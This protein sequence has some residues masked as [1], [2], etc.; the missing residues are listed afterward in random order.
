MLADSLKQGIFAPRLLHKATG[1]R[2]SRCELKADLSYDANYSNVF[3]TARKHTMEV[4][5]SEK[6]SKSDPAPRRKR[7]KAGGMGDPN[8]T[9]PLSTSR[10]VDSAAHNYHVYA[11]CNPFQSFPTF[12]TY[13]ELPPTA[14]ENDTEDKE[15]EL[16]TVDVYNHP[17]FFHDYDYHGSV[18][19]YKGDDAVAPV[20]S[21]TGYYDP[22]GMYNYY[23]YVPQF[24]FP[25]VN[26]Y[27]QDPYQVTRLC[28]T[29]QDATFASEK[30][31][32]DEPDVHQEVPDLGTV[33]KFGK[34]VGEP[35]NMGNFAYTSGAGHPDYG[36][37]LQTDPRFYWHPTPPETSATID[38]VCEYPAV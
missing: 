3:G 22:Y 13:Q 26:S 2:L 12:Q 18:D 23:Q 19:C 9:A 21:A 4:L 11:A 24:Q 28:S 17:P 36:T 37:M 15:D 10:A 30:A 25:F 1:T 35:D 8:F 34:W 29:E 33:P 7:R 20:G 32:V 14:A 27:G 6:K 38:T 31:N 5:C 16:A